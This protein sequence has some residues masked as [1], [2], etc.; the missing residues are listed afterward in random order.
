[1]SNFQLLNPEEHKNLRVIV[2]HGADLGDAVRVVQTFPF[3]FRSVQGHFPIFLQKTPD[4]GEFQCVA[5]LG[6]EE[7]ENLFLNE[8]GWASSYI[9]LMIQRQP[10]LIG[11]QANPESDEKKPVVTIDM[12]N[13]K[14]SSD[15]G[16][17]LF[18]EHGGQSE[19]LKAAI[20]RLEYIHQGHLH[21]TE[22]A[23]HIVDLGLVEAFTLDVTLENGSANQ[24]LGFYTINED[25]LKQL[26]G[27][28]FA[29][30]NEKG[31]LQPLFMILASHSCI[32]DL[33]RLKGEKLSKQ[34]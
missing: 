30:L 16:E 2:E 18:L 23:K 33:A 15:Q 1:M 5:L 20:A 22:F 3:E 12:D 24:L 17:R 14:V 6:F 31:Y 11:F 32:G 10:F 26:T 29:A 34:S 8:Q 21:G 13:P 25:A 7:G 4:T 27:D 28:Q 19:Y 9:P